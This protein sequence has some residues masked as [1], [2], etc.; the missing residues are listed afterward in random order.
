MSGCCQTEA[1][2]GLRTRCQKVEEHCSKLCPLWLGILEKTLLTKNRRREG[3]RTMEPKHVGIS[4]LLVIIS[5]L[6]SVLGGHPCVPM[7]FGHSSVVCVCNATYCDTLDPLTVPALGNYSKYESS[8]DG[9]RLQSSEGAILKDHTSTGAGLVLK[10]NTAKKYQRIKGFGGAMTDAAALNI[11]TLSEATQRHLLNSYFSEEGLEY[12]LLRV[13][14]AS[15]DFSTRVYTYDDTSDDFELKNFSLQLEDTLMKI[16]LIQKVEAISRKPLSLF[17]SPWTSPSWLKTNELPYGKG[18][19][20]GQPGNKYHKTWANYFVRFLDEY[21]KYNLTFWAVTAQNEPTSGLIYGYKF[22]TLGFTAEHQRD[23]IALD[24]GPAL[25][26]SNHSR[27][28]LLILDDNRLLLP[29]W[30]KVVLSDLQAAQYINGIGV[31]WYFDSLTPSDVT[32]GNTHHQYPDYFLIA[33]EASIGFL[34]WEKGVRLGCWNRGTQYSHSIIQDLNQYV[35]GWT[36]WNLALNLKGGPNWVENFADSPIIIDVTKDL[37]YKQPMFYHIA[38]F[39]KFIVEGS[40]RVGLEVS[41]ENELESI[42]FLRPDGVA[43][44]VTLNRTPENITFEISDP[45]LGHI[46]ATSPANSIQTYLWKRA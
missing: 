18:T 9:K 21:S 13:P 23:F 45:E 35:V 5:A 20:K 33:T 8:L 46:Q 14:M 38:H 17:A 3:S 15:C 29:Y 12:N 37:F 19:L 22:Q 6:H 42:A 44:L 7:N 31:H 34:P 40:R 25:K 39:S 24:L 43:V 26:G 1:V 2:P 27:V 41:A 11:L 36:D 16:P 28:Q 10:L 30:A 32:L 4:E